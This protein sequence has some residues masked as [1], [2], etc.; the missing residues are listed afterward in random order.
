MVFTCLQTIVSFC[1][2]TVAT[3]E[4]RLQVAVLEG[5]GSRRSK[6]SD[7]SGHPPPTICAQIDGFIYHSL[8]IIAW[9]YYH[10]MVFLP[11]H[12]IFTTLNHF[13]PWF[14]YHT[15]VLFTLVNHG[16]FTIPWYFYHGSPYFKYF[17]HAMVFLPY[18]GILTIPCYFYNTMVFSP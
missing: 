13:L 11:Y 18:N 2:S 1:Q 9:F 6:I 14:C 4:Y 12:G 16:I 7:T 5:G 10:T 15:M 17:Y 3:G 8:V